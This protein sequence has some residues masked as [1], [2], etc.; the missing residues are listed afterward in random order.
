MEKCSKMQDI[1]NNYNTYSISNSPPIKSG[2]K[3]PVQFNI[4]AHTSNNMKVEQPKVTAN[5]LQSL[6]VNNRYSYKEADNQLKQ[7]NADIYEGTKKEKSKH[8]FNS[9]R[10]F[11]IFGILSL[12]TVAI[13]CFR[14]RK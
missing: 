6:P 4:E 13:T 10:Y 14:K 3:M 2:E 1:Q 5:F 8:E 11:T 7:I 9:K 12:L